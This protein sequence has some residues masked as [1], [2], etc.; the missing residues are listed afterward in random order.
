MKRLF[1]F[2]PILLLAATLLSPATA[3]AGAKRGMDIWWGSVFPAL[4]PSFICVRLAEKLGLLRLSAHTSRGQ[5]CVATVFSLVSGAPNG[6]KLLRSYVREG[7]LSRRE[8]QRLLP[9]VNTV[10]PA[11]LLSI[12]ASGALKNKALFLPM[13]IAFYG[14][15]LCLLLPFMR[16]A[17]ADRPSILKTGDVPFSE[18]LTTAIESSMLDMLRIGGCIVF[19]CT[20]LFLIRPLLPNERIFAALAGCMEVSVGVSAVSQLDLPLRMKSGLMIGAAAFG[21]IS[22]SLQT[23]C[24][25]PE[26]KLIP[27]LIKKLLLGITTVVICYLLFPLFPSVCA[28]FASRQELFSRSL[29]L[30]ALLLSSFLSAAFMAVLSLMACRGN[31]KR[32]FFEQ[33]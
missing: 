32:S 29:S 17:K 20:L 21:G 25:F 23:L 19:V 15:I 16:L 4:L 22:L 7:S 26:L 12:I 31:E 30:S 2:V 1:T 8:A 5:I 3:L 13:A 10:S 18:A 28:A 33:S 9:L 11:F 24:C 6:A 14:P 27:Y